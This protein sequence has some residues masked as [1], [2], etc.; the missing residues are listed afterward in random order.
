ME[1]ALSD[2]RVTDCLFPRH[3]KDMDEVIEG[4]PL[5]VGIICNSLFLVIPNTQFGIGC[6]AS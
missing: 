3:A 1:T 5:M 4:F 6:M 2:H